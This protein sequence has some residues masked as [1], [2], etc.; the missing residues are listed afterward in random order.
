MSNDQDD[1]TI[2]V[3]GS[4]YNS[5]SITIT[6]DTT[7]GVSPLTFINKVGATITVGNNKTLTIKPVNPKDIVVNFNNAGTINLADADGTG[8][9][10]PSSADKTLNI[11]NTGVI[12]IGNASYEGSLGT[13]DKPIGSLN[14][15]G[16]DGAPVTGTGTIICS[17]DTDNAIYVR[18][19]WRSAGTFDPGKSTVY[20]SGTGILEHTSV[21]GFYKL[22]I[23]GGTRTLGSDLV[24]EE[25]LTIPSGVTFNAGS[26]DVT[27][28]GTNGLSVSGRMTATGGT[29]TMKKLTVDGVYDNGTNDVTVNVSGA[30]TVNSNGVVIL[31]SGDVSVASVDNNGQ[32]TSTSGNLIVQSDFNNHASSVFNHNNG[33]VIFTNDGTLTPKGATF[34]NIIKRGYGT[35]TKLGG[36]L[37]MLGA[38]TVES[39]TLAGGSGATSWYT[40]TVSGNVSVSGVLNMGN[41]YADLILNP[42][43]GTTQTFDPGTPSSTYNDIT[44]QGEGT[45]R[46]INNSLKLTTFGAD[47][48]DLTVEAGIFDMGDQKVTVDGTLSTNDTALLTGGS[49]L[50]VTRS[51]TIDSGKTLN[52]GNC[53]VVFKYH[54]TVKAG[55]RMTATGGSQT[56]LGDLTVK[57]VLDLGTNNITVDVVGTLENSG[58]VILGSGPVSVGSLENF[59]HS[60]GVGQLTL[61]SGNL[62]V[63][64][65]FDNDDYGGVGVGVINHNGGTITFTDTATFDTGGDSIEYNNIVVSGHG[66][67]VSLGDNL[68]MIGDL[69]IESGKLDANGHNITV[70]G[71]VSVGGNTLYM[72]T[73]N[74]VLNPPA[75]TTQTF[76]PGTSSSYYKYVYKR[77]GGTTQLINHP[78]ELVSP[79]GELIVEAGTFDMGD[80]DVTV[81][82]TLTI[83]D[84]ARMTDNTGTLT[85]NSAFTLDG[86][87]STTGTATHRFNNTVT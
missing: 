68:N 73:K 48:G 49:Q 50:I 38:L 1:V 81:P 27:I 17:S 28:K 22:S 77:G 54:V 20:L 56:Y 71:D 15:F 7:I 74:L 72:G 70:S 2:S 19:D 12:Y 69:T 9:I 51:Q 23:T 13:S 24:V 47:E 26:Y 6:G 43:A 3:S 34:Y 37:T 42:S 60:T 40:I 67:T 25:D 4:L 65:D 76:D 84:T 21:N 16:P 62:T 5:G 39:G 80:Q 87:L 55:G 18:G 44:K 11:L 46:L 64:G 79:G 61:T 29:Q 10:A 63:G 35:T 85:V 82:G 31:G 41:A 45:T 78:L 14:N 59:I 52:F 86:T 57:G 32:L 58:I 30:L 8:T 53:N 33:T 36:D 75:G 66:I 83:K